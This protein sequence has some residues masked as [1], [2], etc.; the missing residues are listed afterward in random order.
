MAR[1]PKTKKGK[2]VRVQKVK[3]I[4][5]AW[6]AGNLHSGSKNGPVVSNKRQ[7]IAI[8]LSEAGLSRRKRKSS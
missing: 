8:A 7:G 6:K 4:M 5:H 2:A 1:T 3:A